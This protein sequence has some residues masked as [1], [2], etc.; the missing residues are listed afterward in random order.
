MHLLI[1]GTGAYA[2][3]AITVGAAGRASC[4]M[5]AVGMINYMVAAAVYCLLARDAGA[6]DLHLGALAVAGGVVFSIGFVV[7]AYTL[8]HRGL[9][10]TTGLM[11]LAVLFPVLAG[12]FLYAERPSWLQAGGIV[13]ALAAL[14]LLGIARAPAS[15]AGQT[16]RVSV[17]MILQL[18][19]SGAA[20][21]ILQSLAHSGTGIAHERRLFFAI[22]FV[23]AMIVSTIA[24]LIFERQLTRKD[25][26][27]GLGIG[28]L[29]AVHGFMLVG[30]MKTLPGMV[31]WPVVGASALMIS[32]L[33]GVKLWQ[34]QL[35]TAGRIGMALALV[36]VICIN[37]GRG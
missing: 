29:N 2:L 37:V 16:G 30:A 22:L 36:A 28:G 7:L 35:G 1:L 18:L 23:T 26:Y 21:V 14:P 32:V 24:W 5:L 15:S 6:P 17:V 3:F 8:R 9:S 34:E 4:N 12:V 11:Q 19:I 33:V 13:C 20:M 10:V 27:Y 31:V 25:L